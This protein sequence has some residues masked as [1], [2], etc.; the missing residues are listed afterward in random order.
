MALPNPLNIVSTLLPS[1]AV[2]YVALFD[3]NYN[4][5]FREA[6]AIKAVV[7]EQAKLM[8]HPLES[9]AVITDHRV[10]LPIE[11]DLS[12]VLAS[13]DYVDVYKSIRQYFYDATLIVVQTK[14]GIYTNQLIAAMPHEEDPTM[15]DAV[16]IA[17]SLKQVQFATAQYGIVPKA[18]TNSTIV[19]RGT[20]QGTPATPAQS[21]VLEG[22]GQYFG[23][24]P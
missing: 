1:Y 15:F 4:Q 8:E 2:D 24:I 17:L 12:L 16:T 19:N 6:R 5:I 22:I 11:I 7:K 13:T 21:T 14:A 20:Q 18:A 10:V 3:Q 23:V 9:G